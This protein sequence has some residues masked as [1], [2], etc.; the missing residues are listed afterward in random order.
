MVNNN[1]LFNDELNVI[2]SSFGLFD[3]RMTHVSM[4]VKMSVFF[5]LYFHDSFLGRPLTPLS[6]YFTG[7]PLA[8]CS[9]HMSSL[10]FPF[11]QGSM[12]VPPEYFKPC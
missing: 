5:T 10:P 2:R 12:I 3:L 4:D 1:N 9:P 7:I 8:H 6:L 11:I